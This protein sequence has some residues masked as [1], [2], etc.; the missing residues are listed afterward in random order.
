MAAAM[1]LSDDKSYLILRIIGFHT[2]AMQRPVATELF[3]TM[4]STGILRAL[5]DAHDQRTRMSTLESYDIWEDLAPRVPRGARITVVV[6]WPITGG[7]PFIENLAVN[8]GAHG[9]LF[10]RH[11]RGAHLAARLIWHT[12]ILYPKRWHWPALFCVL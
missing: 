1:T 2:P 12:F 3:S 11:G 4:A 9:S 5:V 7:R 8:R 10:Q 6:G